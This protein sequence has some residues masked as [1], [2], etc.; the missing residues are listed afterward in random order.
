MYASSMFSDLNVDSAMSRHR[1]AY[2]GKFYVDEEN[3]IKTT[4]RVS[5]TQEGLAPLNP[6]TAP[7]ALK[8]SSESPVSRV[9]GYEDLA[10]NSSGESPKPD[11]SPGFEQPSRHV[12]APAPIDKPP[13]A[14]AMDIA[15]LLSNPDLLDVLAPSPKQSWTPPGPASRFGPIPDRGPADPW[16]RDSQ[17]LPVSSSFVPSPQDPQFVMFLAASVAN[18]LQRPPPSA[19]RYPGSFPSSVLPRDHMRPEYPSRLTGIPPQGYA[20][21]PPS[22]FGPPP[23]GY[24]AHVPSPGRSMYPPY[25]TERQQPF[26]PYAQD[27]PPGPYRIPGPLPHRYSGIRYPDAHARTEMAPAA[28]RFAPDR[29]QLNPGIHVASSASAAYSA[30]SDPMPPTSMPIAY[31][32]VTV[33]NKIPIVCPYFS[34]P[35]GCR[36]GVSCPFRHGDEELRSFTG[37]F[38]PRRDSGHSVQSKGNVYARPY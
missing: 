38:R 10:V 2:E 12:S 18:S 17:H 25:R 20:V 1:E 21:P 13:V 16:G 26:P 32:S 36:D 19:N 5:Y 6:Y 15:G 7:G 27:V 23:S 14:Q 35:Q 3:R 9:F 30:R 29:S 28:K 11:D 24:R 33:K 34:S 4:L 31:D 22:R 37:Q 8:S